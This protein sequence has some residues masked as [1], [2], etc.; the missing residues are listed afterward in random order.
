VDAAQPYTILESNLSQDFDDDL[1]FP[2][3]SRTRV[4]LMLPI[5]PYVSNVRL[6][7]CG[8]PEEQEQSKL[9]IAELMTNEVAAA[10][11]QAFGIQYFCSYNNEKECKCDDLLGPFVEL[12]DRGAGYLKALKGVK[13][14]L[15]RVVPDSGL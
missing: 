4:G 3:S 12:I 6:T 15:C 10:K 14:V 5:N 7:L 2:R 13:W 11:T 9:L 1:G 8:T